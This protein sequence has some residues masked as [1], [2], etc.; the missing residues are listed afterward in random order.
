MKLKPPR[1]RGSLLKKLLMKIVVANYFLKF[2]IVIL[3]T[4]FFCLTFFSYKPYHVSF[5]TNSK[6]FMEF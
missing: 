1:N 5:L 6:I 3:G 4:Y 2:M